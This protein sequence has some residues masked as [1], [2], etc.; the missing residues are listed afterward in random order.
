MKNINYFDGDYGFNF[1][2]GAYITCKGKVLLQKGKNVG[3]YNLVGG[4]VQFGETTDEALRREVQEELGI[5][6]GKI[7]LI[8]IAENFFEW[9]GKHA[10]EIDFVYKVELPERYLKKFEHFKILDQEEESVWIDEK[11][12][13]KAECKP[14]Y[15]NKL[16]KF[17]DYGLTRSV[18]RDEKCKFVK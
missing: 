17:A 6:V 9:C 15:I 14:Y 2:V 8:H 5:K 10:H 16:P 18:E 4:R 11:D 3:F 13:E 12:I 1:R 7:E